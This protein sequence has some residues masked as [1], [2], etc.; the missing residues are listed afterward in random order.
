M[1]PVFTGGRAVALGLLLAVA[2]AA[3][4]RVI[5]ITIVKTESPTYTGQSFGAVGQY[6]R[7][8]GTASGELDP[9]D[10]HNAI[11][12]DL[13]LAPFHDFDSKVRADLKTELTAVKAD[14]VSGKIKITSKNQPKS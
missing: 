5:K 6:E 9:A 3:D 13:G 2:G 10:R 11:I 1:K 7:V 14:I 12:Q 8:I 4:A